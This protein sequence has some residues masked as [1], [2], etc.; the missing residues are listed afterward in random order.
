MRNTVMIHCLILLMSDLHIC[1]TQANLHALIQLKPALSHLGDKG[2]LLLLRCVLSDLMFAVQ[3]DLPILLYPL[4][5]R[6][7]SIPKGFSYLNERGYVSK[8]MEKWHKVR[9]RAYFKHK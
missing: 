7:L 6:F 9:P 8:Q 1:S 2:L 3:Q 4:P 5:S